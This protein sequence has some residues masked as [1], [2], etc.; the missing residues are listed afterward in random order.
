VRI[1]MALDSTV[2]RRYSLS[3]EMKPFKRISAYLFMKT[4][5]LSFSKL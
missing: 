4:F 2:L 1:R 3:T 5:P